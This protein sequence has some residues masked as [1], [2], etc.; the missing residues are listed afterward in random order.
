MTRKLLAALVFSLWIPATAWAGEPSGITWRDWDA[1]V[2]AKAKAERKLVI[3]DL[4]AVWCHWCHVM[5]ERTYGDPRVVAL[6]EEHFLAIK[7]DQDARPDIAN[8]Y[9]DWGWPATILFDPDGKEI[10]KLAGFVRPNRMVSLLKAFIADPT[11]GPSISEPPAI[12]WAKTATLSDEQRKALRARERRQFDDTYGS[13]GRYH[14]FLQAEGV[15]YLLHRARAGDRQAERDALKTLDAQLQLLDPVWGGVYQYSDSGVWTNP[16]FEKI[17]TF[18]AANIRAYAKAAGQLGYPRFLAAAESI[19]KYLEDFL[20]SP[21]GA[22]YVSQ[23]ADLVQGRHA[24]DYY[25]RDDAGRRAPGTPKVDTSVYSL[26]NGLAIEA[27]AHLYKVNANPATLARAERAAR[28]IVH[29]R[30]NGDGTFRHGEADEA[31]PF[32]GDSLAMADAF[33]ALHQATNDAYWLGLAIQTADAITATFVD[34]TSDTPGL[35]TESVRAKR[36]VATL[37]PVIQREENVKAARFFA[38]LAKTTSDARFEK[39][40][41]VAARYLYTEAIAL[42]FGAYEILLVDLESR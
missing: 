27:L 20:T 11:P 5:D 12:T 2:F 14:K 28:F 42:G 13:W 7:V 32:L 10:A 3:V 23:D 35:R 6:L 17:M 22:F 38:A 34:A 18:Q 1:S 29:Y 8:R 37:A 30:L 26:Q 16:H 9:E 39:T 40:R 33:L 4:E 24:A 41:D 21:R 36:A 15:E 19:E 25:A 31:G